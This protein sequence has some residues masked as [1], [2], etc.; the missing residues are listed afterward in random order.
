MQ[1]RVVK[2]WKIILKNAKR[3][4]MA[5]APMPMTEVLFIIMFSTPMV[6]KYAFVNES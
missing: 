4:E 6:L 2:E 1:W 5:G 3:L